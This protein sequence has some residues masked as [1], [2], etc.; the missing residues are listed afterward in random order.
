MIKKG[1][2]KHLQFILL[3]KSR[4]KKQYFTILSMNYEIN[5]DMCIAPNSKT[6]YHFIDFYMVIIEII[7]LH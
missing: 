4:T 6:I 5:N 2:C 7:T 1:L 3:N